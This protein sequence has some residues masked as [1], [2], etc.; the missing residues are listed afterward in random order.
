MQMRTGTILIVADV[1]GVGEHQRG[2]ER[3]NEGADG[4]ADGGSWHQRKQI[5]YVSTGALTSVPI[6]GDLP[7]ADRLGVLT[8]K[9]PLQLDA[10]CRRRCNSCSR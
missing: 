3:H 5:D 8:L 4:W 1:V 9:F 6:A 7:R 2:N 10:I